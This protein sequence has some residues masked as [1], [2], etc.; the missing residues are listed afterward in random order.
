M[1]I[2]LIFGAIQIAKSFYDHGRFDVFRE[3]FPRHILREDSF[4]EF[5]DAA[6]DMISE[7]HHTTCKQ[8]YGYDLAVYYHYFSSENMTAFA[9]SMSRCLAWNP[10][11]THFGAMPV[12][13]SKVRYV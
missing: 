2:E 9:G 4:Y 11:K 6:M 10:K 8:E 3:T 12:H 13:T 5:F 7:F 1:D